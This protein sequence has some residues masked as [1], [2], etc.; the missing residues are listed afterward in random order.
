MVFVCFQY[1]SL[2]LLQCSLVPD[3]LL[4]A[5][6]FFSYFGALRP[7]LDHDES[8]MCVSAWNDNGQEKFINLQENGVCVSCDVRWEGLHD[9]ILG[10]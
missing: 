2:L 1:F 7:L 10:G 5:P 4:V 8:V 3:D 9:G 6:D